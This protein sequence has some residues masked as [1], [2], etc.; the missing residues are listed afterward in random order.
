MFVDALASVAEM[1]TLCVEVQGAHKM[2][3]M[4][5]G[6]GK[7]PILS[8]A[9]LEDLG[10]KLCAYPLTLLGV[11]IVAMRSALAGLKRGEVPM[12]PVL[13]TFEELQAVVGFPEYFDQEAKYAVPSSATAGNGSGPQNGGSGG[14][15]P[16]AGSSPPRIEPVSA[17]V[18]PD[19]VIE[20]GAGRSADDA[21]V[22]GTVDLVRG[23]S[24]EDYRRSDSADRR[25]QWLRIKVSDASSGAVKLDTRFPAGFL[26]SVAAIIPQVAGLDL[27][28]LLRGEGFS[29][30]R[31]DEDGEYNAKRRAGEPVFS[32]GDASDRIEIY[33]EDKP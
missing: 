20:P 9:E 26:G 19:V 2:A 29:G 30:Q 7:T 10:F 12:P 21:F 11:S 6:G 17:F 5:E 3:N 16:L 33:I 14:T 31:S 15:P 32:F 13:P 18:E 24:D 22:D 4:L 27:E 8:A 23:S 1:R 28:A 25:A